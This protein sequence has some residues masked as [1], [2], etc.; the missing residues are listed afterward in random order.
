MYELVCT[1]GIMIYV[2]MKALCKQLSLID[3]YKDR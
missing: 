3:R 1:K 2:H